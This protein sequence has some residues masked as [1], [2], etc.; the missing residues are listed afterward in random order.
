MNKVTS[1][2]GSDSY[3]AKLYRQ[4]LDAMYAQRIVD[5][6][7]KITKQDKA[8]EVSKLNDFGE[9]QRL[10]RN[11]MILK[12]YKDMELYLF[13]CKKLKLQD[14][15]NIQLGTKVDTFS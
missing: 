9:A 5:H 15:R 12:Q 1:N 8:I 7:K 6:R 3:A 13:Q 14:D 10:A 11:Q 4:Q 2:S